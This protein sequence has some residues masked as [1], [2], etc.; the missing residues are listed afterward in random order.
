VNGMKI[1]KVKTS[2]LLWVVLVML[3]STSGCLNI[4]SY[5]SKVEI[6]AKGKGIR[7]AK[8]KMG[9]YSEFSKEPKPVEIKWDGKLNEYEIYFENSKKNNFRLMHLRTKN[10]LLQVDS[11][12]IY[13]YSIIKI[14][15]DIVDF[16]DIKKDYEKKI[17]KLM[18]KY[19]LVTDEEDRVIGKRKNLL[20]FFKKLVKAK[21]LKSGER[22]R[23]IEGNK[24]TISK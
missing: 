10:Y 7:A 17:E 13:E 15:G 20:S 21:Y 9:T 2:F 14:E 23:Y 8:F 1:K 11:E 16:L 24:K 6:I 22:I 19:N 12:D 3:L 4:L 5:Q 18:K